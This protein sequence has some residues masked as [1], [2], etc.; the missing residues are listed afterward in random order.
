MTLSNVDAV[1]DRSRTFYVKVAGDRDVD[2][3][4]VTAGTIMR[5]NPH[6][7]RDHDQT[8]IRVSVDIQDGSISEDK[9]K[10]IPIVDQASVTNETMMLDG[11]S[12]LLGGMTIAY[13][14]YCAF[15]VHFPFNYYMP[16]A[17][18][19][20][21]FAIGTTLVRITWRP[22]VWVGE[23]SYSVYLLHP[24]VFTSLL[25]ALQR[26]APDSW[27]RTR[28]LGLYVLVTAASTLLLA[29]WTYRRV[30]LPAIRAGRRLSQR[31][32]G[33]GVRVAPHVI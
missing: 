4:N 17:L 23:I 2:L 18:A 16:Y 14:L 30:E 3:F 31:W 19:I 1:F 10:G 32:F 5:V 26:T 24:V 9:V 28:H 33:A 15:M 7:F 27:W 20:A 11:Q 25:W 29:A 13:P 12:L 6:V 22:L 21:V 8:R